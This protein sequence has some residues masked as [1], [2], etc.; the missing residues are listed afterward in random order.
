M[1][2]QILI[3]NAVKHNVISAQSPLCIQ[4]EARREALAVSNNVQKKKQVETSN[5]QGLEN[6][7]SLYR[8][9]SDRPLQVVETDKAFIVTLP[10]L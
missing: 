5:R 4:I 2:L 7:R 9:L 1:T 6:L 3:E 8:Y 10:L